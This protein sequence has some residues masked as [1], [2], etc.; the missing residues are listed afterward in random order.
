MSSGKVRDVWEF[1]LR[2]FRPAIEIERMDIKLSDMPDRQ[3][4][5]GVRNWYSSLG[6][7]A[8]LAAPALSIASRVP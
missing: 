1:Q 8:I 7:A 6:E 2:G 4:E 5:P 3:L